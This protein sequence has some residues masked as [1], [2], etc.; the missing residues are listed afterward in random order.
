MGPDDE[1]TIDLFLGRAEHLFEC[2]I[3][4]DRRLQAEFNI[5]FTGGPDGGQLSFSAEDVDEDDLRSFLMA[6]RLFTADR[7]PTQLGKM[8]NLVERNLPVGAWRD[9][10]RE[11][12][13]RWNASQKQNLLAVQIPGKNYEAIDLFR[14][15][16]NGHY[17]HSDLDARAELE[18]LGDS[19]AWLAKRAL[20]AVAISGAEAIAALRLLVLRAREHAVFV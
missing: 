4:R 19:G 1:R 5:H 6:L 2:R 11:I 10:G 16:I 13:S 7:E 8:F 20:L 17:F 9:T 3:I 18:A 12:R 14:L 15:L